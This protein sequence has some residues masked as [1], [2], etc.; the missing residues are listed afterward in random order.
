MVYEDLN[1]LK[2][3]YKYRPVFSDQKSQKLASYFEI[4]S[5]LAYAVIDSPEVENQSELIT[6]LREAYQ[7]MIKLA[8]SEELSEIKVKVHNENYY[9]IFVILLKHIIISDTKNL[10]NI[11]SY[12]IKEDYDMQYIVQK[13]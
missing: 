2:N 10:K 5:I 9:R 13:K 8:N 11:N 7:D 3:I 6:N 12:I 1:K 4:H